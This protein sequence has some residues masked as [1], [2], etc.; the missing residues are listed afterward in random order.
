MFSLYDVFFNMKD[1]KEITFKKVDKNY[2]SINIKCGSIESK[3][4]KDK[5]EDGLFGAKLC[6]MDTD[7]ELMTGNERL[8]ISDF[9]PNGYMKTARTFHIPM[10][11]DL[12]YDV[13]DDG[14]VFTIEKQTKDE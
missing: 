11:I 3:N 14:T 4:G 5:F 8:D 13:K 7:L 10:H 1:V 2:F 12:L 9:N 6:K